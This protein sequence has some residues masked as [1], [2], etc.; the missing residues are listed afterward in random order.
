MKK[1]K[2][3]ASKY[4]PH[5][6][7]HFE[8]YGLAVGT[9]ETRPVFLLKS[10]EE[11]LILPVWLSSKMVADTLVSVS[12][13]SFT[14]HGIYS[15][16]LDQMGVSLTKAVFRELKGDTQWLDL[17]FEGS[18]RLQTFRAAADG[19]LALALHA[20]IPFYATKEFVRSCRQVNAEIFSEFH[21]KEQLRVVTRGDHNYLM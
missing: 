13:A 2:I 4:C 11:D 21:G 18:D 17:Y 20:K 15:K 7:L 1:E 12:K 6:W 16:L 14:I 3:R 8:P 19:A 9:L 5:Q 10:A